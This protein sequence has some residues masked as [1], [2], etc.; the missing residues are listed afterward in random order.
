MQEASVLSGNSLQQKVLEPLIYN[1]E[2]GDEPNK[3]FNLSYT[4][5]TSGFESEKLLLLFSG[6]VDRIWKAVSLGI[7]KLEQRFLLIIFKPN[8]LTK[9]GSISTNISMWKL[10][11]IQGRSQR[12]AGGGANA[13]PKF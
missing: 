10:S 3:Y 1:N 2:Y 5:E 13:P 9:R 6:N 7:I 12:Q 4:F 11:N 8:F